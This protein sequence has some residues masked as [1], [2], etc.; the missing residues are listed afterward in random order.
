MQTNKVEAEIKTQSRCGDSVWCILNI[1][2]SLTYATW[3][4]TLELNLHQIR[5]YRI[6]FWQLSLPSNSLFAY[7]TI[8]AMKPPERDYPFVK[9]DKTLEY[10]NCN[11]HLL[12]IWYTNKRLYKVNHKRKII[13]VN[14]LPN[15]RNLNFWP[16]PLY[17]RSRHRTCIHYT[18]DIARDI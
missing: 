9:R 13:T 2:L 10:L 6:Y 17:Y 18:T 15:K 14:S 8:I 7:V 5:I 12:P 3:T 4:S 16:N 1:V 11:L